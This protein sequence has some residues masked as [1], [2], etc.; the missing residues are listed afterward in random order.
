V[1]LK[2]DPGN[3]SMEAITVEDAFGAVKDLLSELSLSAS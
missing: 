3:A 1:V 2:G